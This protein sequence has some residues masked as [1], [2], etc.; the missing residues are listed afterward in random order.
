MCLYYACRFLAD[1][2]VEGHC[3][4][5]NYEVSFWSFLFY[6]KNKCIYFILLQDARGDQC[7]KCG[8]LINATELKAS[9]HN[10]IL[11]CLTEKDLVGAHMDCGPPVYFRIYPLAL[12]SRPAYVRIYSQIVS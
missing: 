12:K 5:C 3:P 1:R 7:D 2:F 9:F 11:H 10:Y 4:L 6:Q 8:K